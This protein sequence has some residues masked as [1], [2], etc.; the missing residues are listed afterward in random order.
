MMGS[1]SSV[2]QDSTARQLTDDD[3]PVRLGR[4]IQTPSSFEKH[5]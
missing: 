1:S 4:F 5:T 3:R 2:T